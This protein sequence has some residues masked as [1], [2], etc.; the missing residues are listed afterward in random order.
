MKVTLSIFGHV[1]GTFLDFVHYN[2]VPQGNKILFFKC[3][4]TPKVSYLDTGKKMWPS[5]TS[6]HWENSLS[7]YDASK[8][9]NEMKKRK[10]N[11]MFSDILFS[12]S[13]GQTYWKSASV[14]LLAIAKSVI[15]A[16]CVVGA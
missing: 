12:L 4:F 6:L 9:E 15:S 3:Y 14:W 8:R 2:G 13:W 11:N 16:G 7:V 1:K 10:R 5:K